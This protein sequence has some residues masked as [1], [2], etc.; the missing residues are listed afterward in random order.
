[1]YENSDVAFRFIQQRTMHEY[2]FVLLSAK[3]LRSKYQKTWK[4][5]A[6]S[7]PLHITRDAARCGLIKVCIITYTTEDHKVKITV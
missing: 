7:I 3:I 5:T 1:M 2:D 4:N 6:F